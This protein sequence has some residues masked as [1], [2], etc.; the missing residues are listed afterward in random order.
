MIEFSLDY[1]ECLEEEDVFFLCLYCFRRVP[2]STLLSIEVGIQRTTTS[3][4][5]PLSSSSSSRC[6]G[7]R[8][9]E[10]SADFRV[11]HVQDATGFSRTCTCT[12]LGLLR[13]PS[14]R[15]PS[16]GFRATHQGP[17]G[18]PTKRLQAM[19]MRGISIP[20]TQIMSTSMCQFFMGPGKL[21]SVRLTLMER[22]HFG[23]A[24]GL[25]A[26][27]SGLASHP[28]CQCIQ[29]RSHFTFQY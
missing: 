25:L 11:L 15:G 20:H 3:P 7:L 17:L 16:G 29:Q 27:M 4:R 19:A 22:S 2:P 28:N 10:S 23:H 6:A 13:L 9:N 8:S 5:S 21:H 12:F 1:R 24:F 14:D 26:G 18:W